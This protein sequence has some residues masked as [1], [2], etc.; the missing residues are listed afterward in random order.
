MNWDIYLRYFCELALAFPAAT[1][2]YLPMW[3][4][5]RFQPLR[6]A[7]A[8]AG[9]MFFFCLTG[10]LFCMH[11]SV[12]AKYLL[13]PLAIPVFFVYRC[14]LKV[15]CG[16]ALFVFFNAI[17]MVLFC[18]L[19]TIFIVSSR[20]AG[21]IRSPML[22]SSAMISLGIGIL[23][24]LLTA[25]TLICKVGYLIREF[26]MEKFWYAFSLLPI[27]FST[28]FFVLQPVDSVILLQKRLRPLGFVITVSL[29][30]LLLFLYQL[31]YMLAMGIMNVN[32]LER[33][34]QL[35][36]IQTSRYEQLRRHMEETQN[37]RHDFR[38]HLR[39]LSGL[40]ENKEYGKLTEYLKS[41]SDGLER[42][43]ALLCANTPVDAIAGYYA[44]HARQYGIS[45]DWRLELPEQLPLPEADLCMLLGNLLENSIQ[46]VM[47]LPA[48]DRHITVICRMPSDA[49]LALV[50]ENPYREPLKKDGSHFLS[51]H[52]KGHGIGLQSVQTMVQ[53]HK[54]QLIIQTDDQL[55][56]VNIILNI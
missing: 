14:T 36:S 52:H 56:S 2:G 4:N 37:I 28:F 25:H 12:S 13:P 39:V 30:L 44:E 24:V 29:L 5:L 35:L 23:L 1:F 16:K 38:Q 7:F 3:R 10:A 21:S 50:V 11:F 45:I 41:Y 49:M 20:E 9:S 55:F 19:S 34:N 53:R 46:A 40:A 27:I 33:E 18:P 32:H 51:T 26:H 42:P 31:F 47:Q 22:L 6:F 43:Y 8:V 54:G 48:K 17:A 15:S